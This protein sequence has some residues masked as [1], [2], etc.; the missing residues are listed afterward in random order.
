MLPDAITINGATLTA[1]SHRP[2]VT[3]YSVTPPTGY[4]HQCPVCK[5]KGRVIPDYW[6]ELPIPLST[7]PLYTTSKERLVL[8]CHGDKPSLFQGHDICYHRADE[9]EFRVRVR[10][11]IIL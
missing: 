11:I 9:R 5:T 6:Y 2:W 10:D 7:N 3:A 1:L 4:E 8:V